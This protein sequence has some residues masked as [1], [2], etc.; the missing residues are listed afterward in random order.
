MIIGILKYS[1]LRS[2]VELPKTADIL[3]YTNFY[4]VYRPTQSRLLTPETTQSNSKR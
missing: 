3:K 1:F 2:F 4:A